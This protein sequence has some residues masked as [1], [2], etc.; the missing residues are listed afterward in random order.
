MKKTVQIVTI[1]LNQLSKLAINDRTGKY[2]LAK[3]GT[4]FDNDTDYTPQQLLVLSDDE[5]QHGDFIYRKNE[6]DIANDEW[7]NEIHS[8]WKKIIASYP[9]LSNELTNTLP[10]SKEIIQEWIDNGTSGEGNVTVK[11]TTLKSITNEWAKFNSPYTDSQGYL[12]LEF[13]KQAIPFSTIT[14]NMTV[15]LGKGIKKEL[16]VV[17]QLPTDEEIEEKAKIDVDKTWAIYEGRPNYKSMLRTFKN[18][19]KQALKDYLK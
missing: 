8:E 17:K 9:I 6:L 15:T 12:I 16:H 7:N 19:Y 10:L 2:E 14:S 13:N 3:N 11:Q 5:I 4:L 1:F 18:G